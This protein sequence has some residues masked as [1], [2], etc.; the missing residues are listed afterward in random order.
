[1]P[2]SDD[3]IE[4][5]EWVELYNPSGAAVSLD[6][7][8]LEDAI[9]VA[10]LPDVDLEAGGTAVVVGANTDLTVPAGEM[11]IVLDSARIGTGL[12]NAGDRVALI[13][14]YG[15]RRDAVSW[16]DVRTPFFV[17]RP[18]GH[19]VD[20]AQQVGAACGSPTG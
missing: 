7:W 14:P 19:T 9:A 3:D 1:M 5:V 15:V 17:E 11:L 6:G 2:E 20:R 8:F 10:M 12:R 16:G 13:D 18:G 4:R